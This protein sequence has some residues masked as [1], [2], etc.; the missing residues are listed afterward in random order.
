MDAENK[1]AEAKPKDDEDE[2]ILAFSYSQPGNDGA[3]VEAPDNSD[4]A[5]AEAAA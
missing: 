3:P 5:A 2:A 4:Q 1:L